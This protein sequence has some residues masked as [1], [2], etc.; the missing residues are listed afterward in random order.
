MVRTYALTK[1]EK[2]GGLVVLATIALEILDK[3]PKFDDL[4]KESLLT[5]QS[6]RITKP[7]TAKC[8]LQIYILFLLSEPKYVS[9]VRLAG[10]LSDLS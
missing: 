4:G 1:Q 6:M 5:G 2:C 7:S 3:T 8:N 9:C 10:I